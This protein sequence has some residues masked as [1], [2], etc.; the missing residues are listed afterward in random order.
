MMD[1][2]DYQREYQKNY[3]ARTKRVNL[4]F[5]AAEY[6]SVKSVASSS[7][8]AIASYVKRCALEAHHHKA[9][10]IP[11]EVL[12]QLEDL[13]RMVRI[14]GNNLNQMAKHSNRVGEVLDATEPFV[15]IQSLEAELKRSIA[16]VAKHSAKTQTGDSS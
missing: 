10:S 4:V 13:R 9:A 11:E 5:S 3:Q 6:R 2:N 8:M 14:M 16:L 7:G 15:Y 12:E 1:R